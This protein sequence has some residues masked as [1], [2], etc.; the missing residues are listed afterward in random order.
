MSTT[1]KPTTTIGVDK[2]TF[3]NVISD[4]ATGTSYGEGYTLRGT[5]E[6]TPTD[7]GGNDTFDADNGAYEIDSYIEKPGHDIENADIPPEVDAMWRGL[8]ADSAGGVS[9]GKTITPPYFGVAWRTLHHDGS[10]RY[11]RTYKGKYSFAS[12]VGGKTKPSSGAPEHQTAKATFTAVHRDSDEQIYYYVDDK[13]MTPAQKAEIAQMW[14]TDM[15]Y[16]PTTAVL[17]E[18]TVTSTAGGSG[19]SVIT[20]APTAGTGNTLVYKTDAT[21]APTVA[22]GDDLSAWA[23]L[24]AGGTITAADGE[25]ITVAEITAEGKAK[26]AGTATIVSGT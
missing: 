16:D 25:K 8:E 23:A 5:V 22:Y 14:F 17:G 15:S 18:L 7:E 4:D 20:V 21:T 9:V 12:N 11:F 2:Y 24:P 26:K 1:N 13:N 10:Y 6:I 19:E 3:F